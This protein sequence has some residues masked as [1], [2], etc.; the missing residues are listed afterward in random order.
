MSYDGRAWPERGI[1][2]C[3]L[4]V[5]DRCGGRRRILGTVTEPHAVRRLLAALGLAAGP[6]PPGRLIPRL[7]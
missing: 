5:C 7:R 6:C 1:L 2:A 4:L 3:L